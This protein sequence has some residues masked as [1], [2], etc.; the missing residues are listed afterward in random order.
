MKLLVSQKNALFNIIEGKNLTPSLFSWNNISSD[1]VKTDTADVLTYN[2]SDFGFIFET[3]RGGGI[4]CM[5][6]PG[7]EE[8]NENS[9]PGSWDGVLASFRKWLDYLKR[10][11]VLEDKWKRLK[12]EIELIGFKSE[13]DNNRFSFKEVKE[14]E[15]KIELLKSKIGQIE[16]LSSDSILVINDKLD[17]LVEQS[18]VLTK[19]DWKSFFIGTMLNIV[20]SFMIPPDVSKAIWGAISEVFKNFILLTHK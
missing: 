19:F 18:K 20:I 8:I 3:G 4:Y 7:K 11:I 10:E 15:N 17:F 13:Q 16:N 9:Y 6:T 2:E 1:L 12:E 14:I 5:Y